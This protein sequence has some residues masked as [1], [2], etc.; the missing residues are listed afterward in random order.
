MDKNEVNGLLMRVKEF[1]SY[2]PE[3]GVFTWKVN[4]RA[5][6]AGD[7]AGTK[8]KD[9]YQVIFFKGKCFKAHRL[10]WFFVYNEMP[11]DTIDHINR[12]RD[13]NRIQ[14]LRVISQLEQMHNLGMNKKNRSGFTGV[15]WYT[16]RS[17]WVAQVVYKGEVHYVGMF[18]DA[19]EASMQRDAFKRDLILQQDAAR[20]LQ[21]S[22]PLI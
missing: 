17:K 9:G 14:N 6:N 19:K 21:D 8:D 4:L 15:Y 16:D 18:D 3:T 10:A 2:N 12:V 5:V 13:D 20:M 1:L 22:A 7:V 11:K